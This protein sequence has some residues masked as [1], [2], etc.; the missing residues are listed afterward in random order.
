ML[1]SATVTTITEHIKNKV[2]GKPHALNFSAMGC[3]ASKQH[4]SEHSTQVMLSS[5]EARQTMLHIVLELDWL[6]CMRYN[7]LYKALLK[8]NTAQA[9]TLNMSLKAT[10]PPHNAVLHTGID[11]GLFQATL[12]AAV[13]AP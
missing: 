6:P 3:A 10:I 1:C 4:C 13:S 7:C 9:L 5:L 11:R 2:P 12:A 8:T